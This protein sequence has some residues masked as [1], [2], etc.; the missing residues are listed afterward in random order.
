[1]PPESLT[2]A[3]TSGFGIGII[4]GIVSGVCYILVHGFSGNR[5]RNNKNQWHCT[6]CGERFRSI[7]G[8]LDLDKVI[9]CVKC[10][11]KVCRKKCSNQDQGYW[12][13]QTCLNPESWFKGILKALHPNSIINKSIVKMDP[14]RIDEVDEDLES[15]RTKQKEQV[16]D[17]IERLV[18]GMLGGGIDGAS[19]G[20][21]YSDKQYLP[22]LGQSPCSAHA[23]LKLL[24]QR[25]IQE[26]IGLP[27]LKKVAEHPGAPAEEI[28]R[29][30]EDLLATAII[31]K[32][33]ENYQD[34]L[35]TSSANSVS[36]RRSNLSIP[37]NKEYFFGEE[38]LDSKWRNCNSAAG[39]VDTT[40]VSSMEEWVH[41][42]SSTCSTKYVDHKSLTI[43]QRVQEASS[44]D[45]ENRSKDWQENWKLQ[46]RQ[47][48]GTA[49]PVPV[50][51]LVPNP[52]NEA[53]VLI[54]DREADDTTD[55]SDAGS[56]YG[57][58]DGVED[59]L[60]K[61]LIRDDKDENEIVSDGTT[62]DLDIMREKDRILEQF[63][64]Y[65]SDSID[66]SIWESFNRK[67]NLTG[68]VEDT[69]LDSHIEQD[70][71]YTEKYAT[72]PKT[73]VKSSTP[74]KSVSDPYHV[75]SFNNNQSKSEEINGKEHEENNA[76][77][78]L[79]EKFKGSY[80]EREKQKW[81]NAV[82]MKNNPYTEENINRRLHQTSSAVTSLF[83]RD[84]YIKEAAKA[85]GAR[86]GKDV[87][88]DDAVSLKEELSNLEQEYVYC[89]L[90]RKLFSSKKCS[91]HF[92]KNPLLYFSDRYGT[93]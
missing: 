32:V 88:N 44:S 77:G 58:A 29:T 8:V 82:E 63:S 46:K 39:D 36:S 21:L 19:I 51:M 31:N 49:S 3:V 67:V 89:S 13:C 22:V 10:G 20:R 60:L 54:G 69:S 14:N 33:I 18:E 2:V 90:N 80:S 48:T 28:N 7:G 93:I 75:N 9:T 61:S 56:E 16:R 92:V 17:F 35:P 57:D 70:S 5:P 64:S 86:N 38:T 71:E 45:E 87:D 91:K 15:I 42:S 81:Q 59:N 37:N 78:E 79:G 68:S 65:Q 6:V 4:A 1:M 34:E 27:T 53:K 73:I 47:F 66:G 24:I 25:V 12:I 30:Y 76:D 83:G 84:Y 62:D 23:G 72:L 26:A 41:S 85:T 55:L 50:P 11:G 43:Q 74:I 52:T 40:S